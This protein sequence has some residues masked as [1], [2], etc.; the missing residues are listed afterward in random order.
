MKTSLD[1]HEQQ[2]RAIARAWRA[3]LEA[4]FRRI[5]LTVTGVDR[6]DAMS[7]VQQE[8]ASLQQQWIVDAQ[9]AQDAIDPFR[10]AVFECP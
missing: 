9:A 4:R 10:A 5:R 1:T 7:Q 3:T 2:H 8:V 6:A